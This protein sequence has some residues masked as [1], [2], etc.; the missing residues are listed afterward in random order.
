VS[1]EGYEAFVRAGHVVPE[2]LSSEIA[3]AIQLLETENDLNF[4][5]SKNNNSPLLFS[6]RCNSSVP[7]PGIAKT[8]LNVGISMST[9]NDLMETT[10][11]ARFALNTIANYY[12]AYG[13]L[14][15]SI[16]KS[17]FQSIAKRFEVGPNWV[18]RQEYLTQM[19]KEMQQFVQIPEDP[20]EQLMEVLAA[21]YRDW[22]SRKTRH[23]I[24]LVDPKLDLNLSVVVQ[25]MVHGNLNSNS[26]CG[27]MYSRNPITGEAKLHGEFLYQST[28]LNVV[29][30]TTIT[31]DLIAL[32]REHALVYDKLYALASI[33]EL[34]YRDMQCIE[35][36][37]Q[38]GRLYTLGTQSGK[39]SAVAGV[40]IAVDMVEENL[41]TERESLLRVTSILI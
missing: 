36:T 2:K 13:E 34:R 1:S 11:S 25:A 21:L 22:G 41:I 16:P 9:V 5:H 17:R 19:I 23:A 8:I 7:L 12:Q 31:T 29:E 35:F 3:K 20:L 10:G 30:G 32:Q 33:L 15:L 18:E 37:I 38:D 28:G 27:V 39:R 6:L 26:G 40:K 4:G 24:E 14:V